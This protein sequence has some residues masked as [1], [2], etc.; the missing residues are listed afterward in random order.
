MGKQ[1]LKRLTG[2]SGGQLLGFNSTIARSTPTV[3]AGDLDMLIL[4]I[5]GP[6]YVIAIKG[7]SGRLIWSTQLDTHPYAIITMS[8]TYYHG[9][10]RHVLRSALLFQYII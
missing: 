2:I 3:V 7:S 6:A 1:K 4:G 8:G 5:T 10:A 9:Y